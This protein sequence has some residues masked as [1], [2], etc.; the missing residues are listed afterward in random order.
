MKS[1]ERLFQFLTYKGITK[2]K[3]ER[4]IGLSNGYVYNQL[5]T[6]GAIGSDILN[7]IHLRYPE[8][9]ILWIISGEDK[10]LIEGT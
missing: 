3:F 1:T 4:S 2:H 9:N 7:K 5:K 6:K 8:L 10:M